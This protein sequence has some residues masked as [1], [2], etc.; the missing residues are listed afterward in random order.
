M[1]SGLYV[2]MSAQVALERRLTTLASNIANQSTPGY[3]AE[4]VDFKTLISKAG[5]T[6]IAYVSPGNTYISPRPGVPVKTD[7]PL[8]VAVRGDCWLAL[9]TKAGTIV[10]TRDG[11]LQM[12]PGGELQSIDGYA[13]LDA[14]NSPIA[15][16]PLGGPATIAQ[17]GMITQGGRQIGAIGLFSFDKGAKLKRFDNSSVISDKPASPVLDFSANGITQ[18]FVEGAN[19]NPMQEMAKLIMVS[20]TF[21]SIS[22]AIESSES[23]LK[24]AIRILGGAT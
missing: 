8:D 15:L 11:R 1:Q 23:S 24:D 14:G 18:G 12:Q 2:T 4:E 13:L 17:D 10:Y 6:P 19:V 16:D 5:D 9:K 22:A 7:N 3:K 20:R 21:E